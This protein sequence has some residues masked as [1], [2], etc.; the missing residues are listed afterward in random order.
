MRRGRR[1]DASRRTGRAPPNTRRRW[2]HRHAGRRALDHGLPLGWR[3][4][5]QP[6][7]ILNKP[8]LILVPLVG[9][10]P[11]RRR[12]RSSSVMPQKL[13]GHRCPPRASWPPVLFSRGCDS[14]S[15]D[16]A[17][18][19]PAA[20]RQEPPASPSSVWSPSGLG[21]S[22]RRAVAA[23][24]ASCRRRRLSALARPASRWRVGAFFARFRGFSLA[25]A[26]PRCG[27]ADGAGAARARWPFFQA[28]AKLAAGALAAVTRCALLSWL[29]RRPVEATCHT[30]EAVLGLPRALLPTLRAKCP[31]R[32]SKCFMGPGCRPRDPAPRGR[33][34]ATGVRGR[35][36]ATA[37]SP[38]PC[39]PCKTSGATS[40]RRVDHRKRQPPQA[41]RGPQRLPS[42]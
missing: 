34:A 32:K 36:A 13:I 11:P 35:G 30:G 6:P 9:R 19:V 31:H 38:A 41:S 5:Q 12:G 23:G 20:L 3:H 42:A 33:G 4:G 1:A 27:C 8:C 14:F 24:S 2:R 40:A 21:A 15:L 18:P 26:S 25:V 29:G 17:G 7:S 22:C 16:S 28:K 10:V 39:S 37:R